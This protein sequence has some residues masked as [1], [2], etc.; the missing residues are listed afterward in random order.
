[1][2][3]LLLTLCTMVAI[4][5]L[6]G[7]SIPIGSG[8]LSISSDGIDFNT[9]DEDSDLVDDDSD[10]LTN[11]P[12][13]NEDMAQD[14]DAANDPNNMGMENEKGQMDGKN[15]GQQESSNSGMCNDPQDH[16]ALLN[17]IGGP[18]YFPECAVITS[19]SLGSDNTEARLEISNSNWEEVAQEYREA[20][21]Q[22]DVTEKSDFESEH[23]EFRFKLDEEIWGTSTVQVTQNDN[24]VHL[25]VRIYIE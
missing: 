1:M 3:K 16:S 9:G 2:R 20:L 17:N 12:D 10:V 21:S 19:Q 6:A 5:I 11:T 14:E 18:F 24:D 8:E 15:P 23:I 25:F 7:C 22:Y 4:G 13:E